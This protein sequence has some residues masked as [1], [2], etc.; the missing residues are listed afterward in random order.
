MIYISPISINAGLFFFVYVDENYVRDTQSVHS[1][2][3]ITQIIEKKK[4]IWE[5][6]I[7]RLV[8]CTYKIWRQMKKCFFYAKINILG[9]GEQ[10]GGLGN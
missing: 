9:K 8:F 6:K 2:T 3:P 7:T 1:L 5:K 4:S 10:G